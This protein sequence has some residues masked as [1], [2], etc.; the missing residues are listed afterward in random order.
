M[1][2]INTLQRFGKELNEIEKKPHVWGF[3]FFLEKAFGAQGE[4]WLGMGVSDARPGAGDLHKFCTKCLCIMPVDFFLP[5]WYNINTVREK[6]QSRRFQFHN[7][8]SRLEKKPEMELI[9]TTREFYVC[10]ANSELSDEIVAKANEL[11]QALDRKNEKRKQVGTKNQQENNAIK[12]KI[13]DTMETD[14]EYT[15]KQIADLFELS[16]TQKATAL[17]LQMVNEGKA[18]SKTIKTK[19]GKAIAYTKIV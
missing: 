2:G 6:K 4:K 10:V 19:T 12:T 3:S 9:M 18:S 1:T 15:A 17:L 16:S 14:V 5:L 13:Y 8:F 11:I 7:N